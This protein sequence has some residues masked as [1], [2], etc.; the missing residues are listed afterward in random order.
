[1]AGCGQYCH[2]GKSSPF[3]KSPSLLFMVWVSLVQH[4]R[5]AKGLGKPSA[6]RGPTALPPPP[7]HTLL[8]PDRQET[9]PFLQGSGMPFVPAESPA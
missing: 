7:C 6:H 8:A 2:E 1:M 3:Q 5:G 9:L 4:S